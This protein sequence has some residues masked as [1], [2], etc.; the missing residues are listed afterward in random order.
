[1]ED[2]T[3]EEIGKAVL[4]TYVIILAVVLTCRII[5]S[6]VVGIKLQHIAEAKTEDQNMFGVTFFLVLFFG[7]MGA[8]VSSIMAVALPDESRALAQSKYASQSEF[9]QQSKQHPAK[10]KYAPR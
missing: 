6:L 3:N 5:L 2:V 4:G 10:S 1:M 8:I 7:I 9:K